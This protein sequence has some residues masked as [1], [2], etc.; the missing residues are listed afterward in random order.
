M[1]TYKQNEALP[2]Y[3]MHIQTFHDNNNINS[4]I[5]NTIYLKDLFGNPLNYYYIFL[6]FSFFCFVF[7]TLALLLCIILQQYSMRFQCVRDIYFSFSSLMLLFAQFLK[8]CLLF[9]KRHHVAVFVPAVAT[10][11]AIL[12]HLKLNTHSNSCISD[13]L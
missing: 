10:F 7:M 2:S 11:L 8:F 3:K 1:H 5:Y 9:F 4:Y 12:H 6:R 13:M